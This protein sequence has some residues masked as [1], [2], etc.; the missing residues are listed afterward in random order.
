[1]YDDAVA[2]QFELQEE[3]AAAMNRLQEAM[4]D[5]HKTQGRLG[6]AD[7]QLGR[8]RYFLRKSGYGKILGKKRGRS[9]KVN[10]VISIPS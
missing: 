5:V 3:L 2:Y 10:G 8:T 6:E 1:L 4:Q 7:F 9:L